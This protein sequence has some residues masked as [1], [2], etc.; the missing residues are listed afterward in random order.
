MYACILC[1]QPD[2]D[3]TVVEAAM[4]TSAAPTYFPISGGYTDGAIAA[5]NPSIIAC[6]KAMAHYPDVNQRNIAVLSIG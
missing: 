3:M 5:N 4:R 2:N 6:A 1:V